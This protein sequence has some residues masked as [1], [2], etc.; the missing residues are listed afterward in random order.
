[1]FKHRQLHL[2][3]EEVSLN[4]NAVTCCVGLGACCHVTSLADKC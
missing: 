2:R 3:S 1:M 4:H